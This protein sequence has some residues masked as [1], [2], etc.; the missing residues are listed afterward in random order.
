MPIAG[1]FRI[2]DPEYYGPHSS[3]FKE[4]NQMYLAKVDDLTNQ[5]AD[6]NGKMLSL[7]QEKEELDRINKKAKV[8]VQGTQN[9]N[10]RLSDNLHAS[11]KKL[12]AVTRKYEELKKDQPS[13]WSKHIL[14]HFQKANDI[15][16]AKNAKL[17]SRLATMQVDLDHKNAQVQMMLQANRACPLCQDAPACYAALCG[18]LVACDACVININRLDGR[19]PICRD[20][21]LSCDEGQP[22][23][24]RLIL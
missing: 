6:I 2:S 22:D 7:Q 3:S 23:L 8:V 13:N 5:M 19:C 9:T 10:R 18:H 21:C 12:K 20:G 14:K 15:L 4:L 1:T 17:G 24:L 11:E 16:K